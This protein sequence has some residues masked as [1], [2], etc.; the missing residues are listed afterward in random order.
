MRINSNKANERSHSSANMELRREWIEWMVWL[1]H[2]VISSSN[3]NPHK[4]DYDYIQQ[5]HVINT[6]QV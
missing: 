6:E 2:D 4:N 3:S 5:V 1:K